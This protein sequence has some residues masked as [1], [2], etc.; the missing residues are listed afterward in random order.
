[1]DF[2]IAVPLTHLFLAMLAAFSLPN[3]IKDCKMDWE[4]YTTTISKSVA[5][6]ATNVSFTNDL[7]TTKFTF[8]GTRVSLSEM[9]DGPDGKKHEATGSYDLKNEFGIADPKQLAKAAEAI[10]SA[11]GKSVTMRLERGEHELSVTETGGD[12]PGVFGYTDRKF[13]PAKL[14]WK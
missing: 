1:M 11:K 2:S 5:G 10:L 14:K 4:G 9:L 8:R 13:P 3:D 7:G 12:S 6:D